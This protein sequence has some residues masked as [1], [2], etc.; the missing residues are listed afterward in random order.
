MKKTHTVLSQ[1]SGLLC[2]AVTDQ[3]TEKDNFLIKIEKELEL[4]FQGE[5][6]LSN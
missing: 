5:R 3:E 1:F 4:H 6:M 2:R